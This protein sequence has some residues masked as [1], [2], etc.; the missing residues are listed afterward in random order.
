MTY[1]L[2][3]AEFFCCISQWATIS[4]AQK[5]K[6]RTILNGRRMVFDLHTDMTNGYAFVE[7]LTASALSFSPDSLENDP[8]SFI[9]FLDSISHLRLLPLEE[10]ESAGKEAFC[11]FVNMYHC[12]LQHAML[13]SVDSTLDKR[14]MGHFM[15]TMCYE[16]G[17]DVFSLAEINA[18]I[19]RGKMSRPLNPKPPYIEAPKKSNAYRLYALEYSDARINFVLVSRTWMLLSSSG[20]VCTLPGVVH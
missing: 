17:D 19:L 16:I 6:H 12:L 8:D 18:S 2:Q 20:L 15:R 3:T 14:S 1:Q 13:L 9:D 7:E 4:S 5:H 11:L 10:I